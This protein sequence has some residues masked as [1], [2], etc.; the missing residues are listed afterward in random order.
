MRNL[1]YIVFSV[2]I[3]AMLI[4]CAGNTSNHHAH[5]H[6]SDPDKVRFNLDQFA[7]M[8]MAVDTMNLRNLSNYV[9]SNG[10]LEVPPNNEAL[11]STV[12]GGNITGIKVIEGDAVA[13]GQVLATISHPELIKIQTSYVTEWNKRAYLK[14]EYDR[15]QKL[16]DEKVGSGKEYQKVQSEYQSI[17]GEVLGL[18]AQLRLL[19]ISGASIL[20]GIITEHV[21]I[22]S[23]ISGFVRKVE[24]KIGQYVAPQK[25]MFDIV[26]IDHVH[27]DFMIYE[28]DVAKVKKGQT[29]LF[30]AEGNKGQDIKAE[31]Y[32]VGKNFEQDPKAVHI[33]AEIENKSGFLLPGMYI[34][35]RILV[36]SEKSL[37]LPE[38]GVVRQG[39]QYFV[40]SAVKMKVGE[41][42]K[43]D[44]FPIEVKV[45]VTDNGWTQIIPIK[46]FKKNQKFASKG[47]YYLMA[48]LKKEEAEHSH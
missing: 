32:S 25:E 2:F 31:I 7:T 34:Q 24:V 20:K 29:I 37:A 6:G 35:G 39:E 15:Q 40:F 11:V 44:F 22:K 27:A 3:S 8:Q 5:G 43:W 33:H 45:G 18:E 26:N 47:A 48:E 12:I 38:S 46:P 16:Y 17:N 41:E 28:K 1:K 10:T 42:L 21:Q 23:P 36:D 9:E 13:K 4:G 14:S 19:H 30:T